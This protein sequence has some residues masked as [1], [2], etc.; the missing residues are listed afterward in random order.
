MLKKKEEI[1]VCLCFSL[2]DS[3]DCM[4]RKT[5]DNGGL[6]KGIKEETMANK[7]GCVCVCVSDVS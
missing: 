5:L 6:N 4:E 3:I 2:P 7:A 1:G